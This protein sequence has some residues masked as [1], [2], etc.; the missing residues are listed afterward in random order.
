[1]LQIKVLLVLLIGKSAVLLYLTPWIDI[2]GR[3]SL[4]ELKLYFPY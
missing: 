2:V 3:L 4:D 1:M